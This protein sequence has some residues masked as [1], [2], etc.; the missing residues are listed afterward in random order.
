MAG[1]K[2]VVM[3]WFKDTAADLRWHRHL[4]HQRFLALYSAPSSEPPANV[5]ADAPVMVIASITMFKEST[6]PNSPM[7]IT[8]NSID[9]YTPPS[10]GA[11]NNES[12]SP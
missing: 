12:L 1:G 6:I 11:Y 2:L 4:M 3:A 7:R 8:S 9:L 5:P 10:G